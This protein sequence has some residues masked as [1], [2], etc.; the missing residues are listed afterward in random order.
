MD[1]EPSS[2]S[3][4]DV[5]AEDE[6]HLE[7]T[8]AGKT[9]DCVGD[10]VVQR[11]TAAQ[12]EIQQLKDKISFQS[13]ENFRKEKDLRYLDSKIALLIGHKISAAVSRT[14]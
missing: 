2:P 5:V 14:R 12:V 9:L 13:R 10:D 8:D 11:F 6:G 7:R 3:P 1:S 4:P